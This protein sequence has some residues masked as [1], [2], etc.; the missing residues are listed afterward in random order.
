MCSLSLRERVGVR[1]DC[2]IVCLHCCP[3]IRPSATFSLE[4]EGLNRVVF[5]TERAGQMT[6]PFVPLQRE[7]CS[8][9][10]S[11]LGNQREICGT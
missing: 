3:L 10:Y 9:L 4:G 2:R 7:I 1:G 5:D 6:G 11:R 8:Y